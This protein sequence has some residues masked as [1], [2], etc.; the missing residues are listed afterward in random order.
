[1][2]WCAGSETGDCHSD[3]AGEVGAVEPGEVVRAEPVSPVD[4]AGARAGPVLA[5]ECALLPS[6]PDVSR[7]Q[8]HP[9][10]GDQQDVG[11]VWRAEQRAEPLLG[12]LGGDRGGH[13]PRR[14]RAERRRE[15]G[16]EVL[17]ALPGRLIAFMPG[18][19]EREPCGPG[20]PPRG[21]GREHVSRVPP[22][23][24]GVVEGDAP[25]RVLHAQLV[26][27]LERDLVRRPDQDEVVGQDVRVHR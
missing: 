1:M 2:A 7:G 4:R 19:E 25:H 23:A 24:V 3:Q 8:A 5:E 22:V 27:H 11:P 18:S 20:G 16:H 10:A 6:L 15:R 17:G 13:L 9:V 26:L 21:L 12:R 14:V